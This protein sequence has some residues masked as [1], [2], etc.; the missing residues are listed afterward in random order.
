MNEYEYEDNFNIEDQRFLT[1]KIERDYSSVSWDSGKFY[2]DHWNTSRLYVCLSL[3]DLGIEE[4]PSSS[5]EDGSCYPIFI[6]HW[7]YVGG[8]FIGT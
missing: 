4:S 5:Y 1:T 6:Y 2:L 3:F 8:I 7:W